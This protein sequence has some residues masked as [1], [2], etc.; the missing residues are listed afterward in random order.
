VTNSR[1]IIKNMKNVT[2]L[3]APFAAGQW[4]GISAPELLC[5]S[6]VAPSAEGVGAGALQYIQGHVGDCSMRPA[7]LGG[8]WCGHAARP[9]ARL[10]T[11]VPIGCHVSTELLRRTI[12]LAAT[13]KTLVMV[14]LT[15]RLSG[16]S[17]A[18]GAVPSIAN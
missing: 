3:V 7:A 12:R 5:R 8:H 17:G 1:D 9:A 6:T 16:V 14:G 2:H 13:G 18:K 15:G 11:P 4:A 10:F